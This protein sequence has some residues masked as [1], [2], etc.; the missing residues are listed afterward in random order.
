M[1]V[2]D[3]LRKKTARVATV[4]MNETVAI[5]AQLM[6][7]SNI[8]ALVVKDV[9]RTEGNTAVGMFTERD[10]VRAIATHGAA[11]AGMRVSQFVAVQQL[12]SCSSTDTLDHVRHLMNKHHIRHVPVIDNYS[13]IGV[14]SMRDISAAFDEHATTSVRQAVPA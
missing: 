9:V 6:R 13:L 8:S 2:G 4:R 10:V 7:T 12:V 3:I 14:V 11:G 5:A 1:Q